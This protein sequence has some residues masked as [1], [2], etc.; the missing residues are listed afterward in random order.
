MK[1]ISALIVGLLMVAGLTACSDADTA[2]K[3]LSTAADHFQILRRVSLYN[4]IT[5]K[6]VV[7]VEGYCS[8]GNSDAADRVSLTCRIGKGKYIK[9]IFLKSDNTNVIEEQMNPVGVSKDHYKIVFKP[10]TLIPSFDKQ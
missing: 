5:D 7:S 3:N 8:L 9:D 6:F 1:K 10:E 2:S 4:S